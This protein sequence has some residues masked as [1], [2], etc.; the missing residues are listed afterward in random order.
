[1]RRDVVPVRERARIET[2][3]RMKRL[4]VNYNRRGEAQTVE[5]EVPDTGEPE[6]Q[7]VQEAAHFVQTLED[8]H[9]LAEGSGPLP[10]GATH[11]VETGPDGIKRL[12]RIR[13][14]FV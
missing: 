4:R 14:S 9:Q 3:N 6:E 2:V 11:R 10:L 1:M 7:Q 8:N 13:F 12:V 5:V